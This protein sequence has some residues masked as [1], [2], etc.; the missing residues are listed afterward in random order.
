MRDDLLR[1]VERHKGHIFI[2]VQMSLAGC[3][4]RFGTRL[5]EVIHDRE[6]VH[7]KIPK[8][9]DIVLEKAKIDA[10]GIVVIEL[11]QGPFVQAIAGSSSLRR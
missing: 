10:S 5:D 9:V 11:A 4:D 8:N 7:R 6:I 1:E 3:H 2:A